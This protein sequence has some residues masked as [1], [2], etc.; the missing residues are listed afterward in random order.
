MIM[1]AD[2]V[3]DAIDTNVFLSS[4]NAVAPCKHGLSDLQYFFSMKNKNDIVWR[5]MNH[6]FCEIMENIFAI[7]TKR[8]LHGSFMP[9]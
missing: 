4:V 9:I 7:F 3:T 2:G 5:C 8:P 6:F 1:L